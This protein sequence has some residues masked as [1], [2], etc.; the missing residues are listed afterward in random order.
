MTS[1]GAMNKAR[2]ALQELIL[3]LLSGCFN[4]QPNFSCA[5]IQVD[6]MGLPRRTV[7]PVGG[8]TCTHNEACHVNIDH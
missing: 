7:A 1:R 3:F 5:D 8:P 6:V 4:N 2:R